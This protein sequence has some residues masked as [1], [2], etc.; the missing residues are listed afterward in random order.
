MGGRCRGGLGELAAGAGVERVAGEGVD[1]GAAGALD[2]DAVAVDLVRC[3][4]GH[5][6]KCGDVDAVLFEFERAGAALFGV[7]TG[8][9]GRVIAEDEEGGER[10]GQDPHHCHD[11]S[12]FEAG[13]GGVGAAVRKGADRGV[14]GERGH[15]G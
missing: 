12:G 11:Q 14:G 1:L 6:E 7:E 4:E 2:D 8:E 15:P 13:R 5:A 9:M 10:D 3:G